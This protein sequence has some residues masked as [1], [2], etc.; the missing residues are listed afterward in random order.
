MRVLN[1][2]H[3]PYQ[4]ALPIKDMH[5]TDDRI[6]WLKNNLSKDAWRYNETNATFCFVEK[7]DAVLFKL[8]CA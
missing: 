8:S 5:V 6:I 3:W 7:D 4:F 1:K 2:R